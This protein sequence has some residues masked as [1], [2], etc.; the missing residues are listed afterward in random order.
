MEEEPLENIEVEHTTPPNRRRT[1][2]RKAGPKLTS[3]PGLVKKT[4]TTV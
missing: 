1:G 3:E 2:R 4:K